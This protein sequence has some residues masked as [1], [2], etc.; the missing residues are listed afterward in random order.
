MSLRSL[1]FLL[2]L[3]LAVPLVS[4]C[5]PITPAELQEWGTRTYAG[6]SVGAAYKATLTAVRSQGY[7]IASADGGSGQIKT[8]PKV[9]VVVVSGGQ[10]SAAAASNSI[11]WDFD[12]KS[13]PQGVTIHATPRGYSAGQSVPTSQMS[14]SYMKKAFAT[15]FDEIERNLG[16]APPAPAGSGS[17]KTH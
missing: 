17:A 15:I 14:A 2:V 3:G 8:A 16:V 10:Y 1:F 7:D 13:S 11:A 12:V 6:T 9:M 4:G 5:R